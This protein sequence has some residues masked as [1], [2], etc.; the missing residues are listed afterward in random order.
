MA[1]TDAAGC[2]LAG[3]SPAQH[4]LIQ[5]RRYAVNH[6]WSLNKRWAFLLLSTCGRKREAP[7]EE[8]VLGE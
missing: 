7:M 6:E 8:K 4:N 3:W 5:C 2:W 1:E